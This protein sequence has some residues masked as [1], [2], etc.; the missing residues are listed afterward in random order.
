M[1]M[2]W[3]KQIA[4]R[5]DLVTDN[6]F[7][8]VC[9][10]DSA[11]IAIDKINGSVVWEN[12]LITGEA[13]RS[14]LVN[15]QML[16]AITTLN[17]YAF[18]TSNG[19]YLWSVKLG[20]GHVGIMA[21]LD[22]QELRI[23]YG[24]NIIEI[25]PSTGQITRTISRNSILW[26][27]ENVEIHQINTKPSTSLTAFDRMSGMEL[28]TSPGP[29]FLSTEGLSPR[30]FDLDSL[31]VFSGSHICNLDVSIGKY[32]WCTPGSYI[33]NIAIDDK[34]GIGYM[35]NKNFSLLLLDL[36]TG[37]ILHEIQF[38]PIKL[39]DTLS[40]RWFSYSISISGD[41]IIISFGD[42]HQLFGIKTK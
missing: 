5:C 15:N 14:L 40:N 20:D 29:V 28:W 37:K 22:G 3:E 27:N 9:T 13:V 21:Q 35:L 26:I 25:D 36:R 31:I 42:S 7:V 17:A 18:N 41:T 24:D 39:P 8:F 23:Y 2:V 6:N 11:L 30:S 1:N 33:S 32:L 4:L 16:I 12:K 34:N 38:L 19:N 10:G